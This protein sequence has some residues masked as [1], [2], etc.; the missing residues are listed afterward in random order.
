MWLFLRFKTL[1]KYRSGQKWV[2]SCEHT[3]QFIL[4]LFCSNYCIIFHMHSSKPTYAHPAYKVLILALHFSSLVGV[5]RLLHSPRL[6]VRLLRC[7]PSTQHNLTHLALL[8]F[9]TRW[10]PDLQGSHSSVCAGKTRVAFPNPE[11][12]ERGP[13]S[14]LTPACVNERVFLR[15]CSEHHNG[16]T[17]QEHAR[18]FLCVSFDCLGALRKH[19]IC[20]TLIEK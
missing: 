3:K 20:F 1:R 2:Y 16:Y 9:G 13:C 6:Q 4:L 18:N 14:G 8:S 15:G 11:T 7:F 17:K 12:R 10:V 19:Y 5:F